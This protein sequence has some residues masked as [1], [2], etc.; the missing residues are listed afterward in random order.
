MLLHEGER[1]IEEVA[2][3][4]PELLIEEARR[5]GRRRRRGIALAAAALALGAAALSGW[6]LTG[7]SRSVKSEGGAAVANRACPGVDLGSVAYV[8]FDVLHLLDLSSCRTRILV[9]GQAVGTPSFS[10]DGRYV[11]FGNGFVATSGGPV[12]RIP[13]GGIWSPRTDLLAIVTPKGGLELLNASNGERRR[14]LPDG[15]GAGSPV[16]S[17]DGRTLA[18]TRHAK[19]RRALRPIPGRL[20]NPWGLQLWMLDLATGSRRL[21]LQR[22]VSEQP[23]DLSF[24]PDGRWLIAHE[25]PDAASLGADG[26]PLVA[27]NVHSRRLVQIG[28]SL[29]YPNAMTWCGGRLVYATDFGG[30]ISTMGEGIA[31]AAPPNWHP[32]TILPAGGKTSW[33]SVACTSTGELLVAGGP[34]SD[35]SPFGQEHRS[36]YLLHLGTHAQPQPIANVTPTKGATDELPLW[37]VN[38]RWLIYVRTNPTETPSTATVGHGLLYAVDLTTGRLVGPIANVGQAGDYYGSY[39]WASQIAWYRR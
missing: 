32:T 14:L 10:A 6:L 33:N 3:L 37:S 13:G 27:I 36:L 1:S 28:R 9:R 4:E 18:V 16:F 8:R 20:I 11:A 23:V 38:G 5:R 24:A 35:D 19:P 12:H 39:D 25:Y 21:V 17:P 22:R 7:A 30:R 26:M 31:A 2:G 34:A 29:A 15:W